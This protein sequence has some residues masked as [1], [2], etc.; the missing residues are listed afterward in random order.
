MQYAN[1]GGFGQAT[2]TTGVTVSFGVS[3]QVYAHRIEPTCDFCK[4][5]PARHQFG[6]QKA[7]FECFHPRVA[8][9]AITA[10]FQGT[11]RSLHR[12]LYRN[13]AA[14]YHPDTGC[15]DSVYIE[16]LNKVKEHFLP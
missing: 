11:D 5:R 14:V 12:K 3:P 1:F 16:Q 10:L 9:A 4:E 13:L 15:I 7:C 2:G 6:P 8:H